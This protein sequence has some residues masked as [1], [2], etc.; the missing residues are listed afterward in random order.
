MRVLKVTEQHEADIE[1]GQQYLTFRLGDD[2]FAVPTACVRELIELGQLTKVPRLPPSI[3]GVINLRGRV[4][5][6]ID[7][8]RRLNLA[9]VEVGRR[10]C[11]VIMEIP[12]G[13]GREPAV[14]GFIVDSVSAV[15]EIPFGSIDASPDFGAGVDAEFVLGMAKLEDGLVILLDISK[16]FD[17]REVECQSE[18][19]LPEEVFVVDTGRG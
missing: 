1:A 12:S 11:I 16:V 5:P 18:V 3:R 15:L 13:S 2:A 19:A 10:A 4:V 7:L 6:V 17:T 8:R 9:E 14:V